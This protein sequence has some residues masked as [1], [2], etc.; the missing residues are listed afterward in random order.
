MAATQACFAEGWDPFDRRWYRLNETPLT[1]QEATLNAR[2]ASEQNQSSYR[3]V[4]SSGA[5]VIVFTPERST[6]HA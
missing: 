1:V 5:L 2:L 4:E 6:A 3:V